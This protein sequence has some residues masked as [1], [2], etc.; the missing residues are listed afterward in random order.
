[1]T[2]RSFIAALIAW[3]LRNLRLWRGSV[4]KVRYPRHCLPCAKG[5]WTVSPSRSSVPSLLLPTEIW[6]AIL[7]YLTREEMKSLVSTCKLFRF[8][9]F[10]IF[11]RTAVIDLSQPW[12]YV[13]API[14][15]D[16]R[17][18]VT[19][20][21]VLMGSQLRKGEYDYAINLHFS[22]FADFSNL[23]EFH[24]A[25]RYHIP[26]EIYLF[27]RSHR[28]LRVL[29]IESEQGLWFEHIGIMELPPPQCALT[30]AS[31]EKYDIM[32]DILQ[33]ASASHRTIAHLVILDVDLLQALGAEIPFPSLVHI[34]LR[35]T[36]GILYFPLLFK[37][38]GSN[39][40]LERITLLASPT[41]LSMN[42]H[43]E[44]LPELPCL[45]HFI[46]DARGRSPLLSLAFGRRT[47][48][49]L[50]LSNALLNREEVQ[51]IH[52]KGLKVIDVALEDIVAENALIDILHSSGKMAW[53]KA[54]IRIP[55]L[56]LWPDILDVS[57]PRLDKF[58]RSN[59]PF[60]GPTK[61]S[62]SN[63]Q[64]NTSPHTLPYRQ[65]VR[66][67]GSA[68]YPRRLRCTA[69]CGQVSKCVS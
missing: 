6:L 65:P 32:K 46:S 14:P 62:R 41:N 55:P 53:Q 59:S 27:L 23:V 40:T 13:E 60:S 52:W 69:R 42:I 47:L 22:N 10:P 67:S 36:F 31:I 26:S 56:E 48:G 4:S 30:M 35:L 20:L 11:R 57:K 58:R 37:F 38:L 24:W 66:R 51:R 68:H 28:L 21:K 9:L 7:E 12:S 50:S 19:S 17:R 61:I 29:K 49:T 18:M 34:E 3:P 63:G 39:P 2:D 43:A 5:P 15:I 8:A 64:Q 33:H 16:H 1:M 44:Q 45:K 25:Q 54:T